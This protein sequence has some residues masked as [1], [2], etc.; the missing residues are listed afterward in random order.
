[1]SNADGGQPLADDDGTA[2]GTPEDAAARNAVE[3]ESNRNKLLAT[4]EQTVAA[5]RAERTRL[6]AEN[7]ALKRTQSPAA[8]GE[9]G[10]PKAEKFAKI[11]AFAT[12]TARPDLEADVTS[13]MLLEAFGEIDKLNTALEMTQQE[14]GN[15]RQIDRLPEDKRKRVEDHFK[16]NRHRLG[17][18]GA[19]EAEI[20]AA[21][22]RAVNAAQK[23]EL[24]KLQEALRNGKTANPNAPPMLGNDVPALKL[25]ARTMTLAQ[26]NAEIKDLPTL[27]RLAKQSEIGT[28][29]NIEG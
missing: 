5:E 28:T 26:F 21:D 7:E 4:L 15:L 2:G 16:N 12:G 29:I 23:A 10:D 14:V 25:K 17:D 1:M 22:L 11:K 27:A 9:R 13:E 8:N 18:V 20:D 6:A 3:A 19:A 24:E